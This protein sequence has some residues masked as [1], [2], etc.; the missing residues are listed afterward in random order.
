MV[1][2]FLKRI[3]PWSSLAGLPELAWWLALATFINRAGTMVLPFLLLYLIRHL[4][5]EA[6]RASWTLL[7][8]GLCSVVA[9]PLS[10][11]LC[12]RFGCGR[13]VWLSLVTSALALLA[14]PLAK[15]GV[16]VGGLT[17]LMAFS[18][19]AFRPANLALQ[20]HILGPEHRKRGFILT[21]LAANAGMSIGPAMG[22]LLASLWFPSIFLVDGLSA[23]LAS[24]LLKPRVQ[25][26]GAGGAGSLPER[27]QASPLADRRFR[28]LLVG[29]VVVTLG[30]FQIDSTLALTVVNDLGLSE[31]EFGLIFT[32]NTLFILAFEVAINQRT[33]S[34]EP[35]RALALGAVLIGA[36]LGASALVRDLNTLLLSTLV[37]TVGE[38]L[39]FP[40]QLARV[41]DIAPEERMG[42]YMG[43]Q[44]SGFGLSFALAPVMGVPLY[45]ALGQAGFWP[46]V[47]LLC[48]VGGF[49][50]SRD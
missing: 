35:S 7:L 22:G 8:Y 44:S 3:N 10:G 5:W 20:A 50:A 41:A 13:V 9:G 33:S 26:I 42:T 28:W 29:S 36:G 15:S 17:V 6:D 12:D 40:A 23:L 24:L 4:G 30:M 48:A 46:L 25:G 18:G 2:R 47:F 21:R 37:W 34:W 31:R 19:G 32:V 39:F 11:R 1:L 43:Y 38:I 49:F 14:F 16:G 27:V 45:H